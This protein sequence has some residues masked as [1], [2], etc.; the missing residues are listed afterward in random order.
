METRI[1]IAGLEHTVK[2]WV[3]QKYEDLEII[4]M[5][6]WTY[7]CKRLIIIEGVE[8]VI[9]QDT[10]NKEIKTSLGLGRVPAQLLKRVLTSYI[11]CFKKCLIDL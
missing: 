3:S 5:K 6:N 7:H 8:I 1:E 10:L 2:V 11:P 9:H 4:S